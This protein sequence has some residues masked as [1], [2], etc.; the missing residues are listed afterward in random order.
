MRYLLVSLTLLLAPL[1]GQDFGHLRE[2][3]VHEQ[4]EAR[5]IRSPEVLAAMRSVPRHLFVPPEIRATAYE[6]RPLPIGYGQTI[7][8]P[9][10]VELMSE[11]LEPHRSHRVLEIGTGSGYQA[12]VLSRIV[13]HVYTIEIIEALANAARARLESLGYS[14]VAV[15]AGD[16]YKGWPEAAPFDRIILTSAERRDETFRCNRD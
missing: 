8:Q 10:I 4:I 2:L 12:A 16:G 5:G 14:N 15:R 11:L 9:I 7:S 6:D 1:A 3:M 13:K